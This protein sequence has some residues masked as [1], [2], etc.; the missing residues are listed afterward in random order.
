M[1]LKYLYLFIL[2]VLTGFLLLAAFSSGGSLEEKPGNEKIIKFSHSLHA[3]LAECQDCHAGALKSTSAK[4][5][6]MPGHPDCQGCHEVEDSDQCSTCHFDDVY[7]PLMQ[8][9]SELI[10]NHSFHVNTQNMSCDECHK[11][12]SAV[13]YGFQAV[14]PFPA[15]VDCYSCHNDKAIAANTCE[16]CHTST[17]NLRPQSHQ[18]TTFMRTHKFAANNF[19]ADC[20]MCH[21]SNNN[22]CIECH[23]A[24][25]ILTEVNLPDNFYQPYA[26]NNFV[27]GARMQKINRV[28]ELNY[29]FIHGIDAKSQRFD[30]QSCH[31]VETFCG[32]C[33]QSENSDYSL[34]GIL[35]ASHLK[36]GFFT[37]GVGTGG[38]EHATLARRN[39]E[40]CV[41]CHDVQG[42]DPTC[43]TCHSDND[44]IKGTNAKTH[45]TGF[46]R[47]ERGDWH[48]SQGSVCYNCH[49]NAS[50]FTPAGMGFCGY[51]HGAI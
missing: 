48:D 37:F 1:K 29:R 6:L 39:I 8:R 41:S 28:H 26:P 21:D 27:D 22:S 47:S 17:A 15:M 46:M 5:R 38:G 19:D 30:C 42:G 11:G 4:D 12:L 34:S 13:D 16:S 9:Q 2:P 36:P 51:C 20:I 3:D 14:Q 25:D 40:S 50:P 32:E 23:A 24:N 10:F 31:Q 45:Q 7:E 43:V 44:G 49:T 35:P 18:S 33:H